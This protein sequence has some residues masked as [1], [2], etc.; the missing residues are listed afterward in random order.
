MDMRNVCQGV[1]LPVAL[2]L[3]RHNHN[4]C[5]QR[6]V[7]GEEFGRGQ[8]LPVGSR[9]LHHCHDAAR[10]GP[11]RILQRPVLIKQIAGICFFRCHDELPLP[12]IEQR[13]DGIALVQWCQN[14]FLDFHDLLFPF[15]IIVQGCRSSSAPNRARTSAG[16]SPP[17]LYQNSVTKRRT[18]SSQAALTAAS[19]LT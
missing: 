9:D 14:C 2:P 5:L 11:E 15:A 6:L 3:R 17:S 10:F 1:H 4:L 8:E 19:K 16:V 7:R 12:L 18:P 13:R